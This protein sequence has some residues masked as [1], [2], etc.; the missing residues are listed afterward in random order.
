MWIL[1]SILSSTTPEGATRGQIRRYGVVRIVM[2]PGLLLLGGAGTYALGLLGLQAT[3]QLALAP[4]VTG[5]LAATALIPWG[6]LELTTAR[7]WSDNPGWLRMAILLLLGV[8]A[9]A[10]MIVATIV[11]AVTLGG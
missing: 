7:R 1:Q 6:V 5:G 2:G 8:P 11:V 10:A 3:S 9:A 4:L